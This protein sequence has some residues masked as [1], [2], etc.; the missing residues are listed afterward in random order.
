MSDSAKTEFS[1]DF[2]QKM[3]AVGIDVALTTRILENYNAG[4]YDHFEPIAVKDIPKVDG[5]RIVD[6]TGDVTLTVPLSEAQASLDALGAQVDLAT[7]GVVDGASVSFDNA[8]L[9]RLGVHLYEVLA[10]GVLNGGSASSYVDRSKNVGFNETLYHICESQFESLQQVS[11]GK[12]KGVT[13]AFI[14]LDGS[15]GPSFLELKMRGVLIEAMKA[16]M[17]SGNRSKALFP[18]FQMTSV[19]NNQEVLEAY[20]EYRE[21][22][23][24]APLMTETGLQ[25]TDFATGVQPMLA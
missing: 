13:P 20:E 25:I 19:Y 11:S 15:H 3:E 18:M 1:A 14:N 7:L 8:A 21:R 2:V 17:V 9:V 10:F 24:I 5:K 12:P 4:K 22:E 23:I 16:Q 6:V